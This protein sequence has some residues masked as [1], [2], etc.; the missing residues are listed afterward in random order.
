M[1]KMA[2]LQTIRQMQQTQEERQR[3]KD[4]ETTCLIKKLQKCCNQVRKEEE[5]LQKRHNK[6]FEEYRKKKEENDSLFDI[7][8]DMAFEISRLT[9]ESRKREKLLRKE[10]MEKRISNLNIDLVLELVKE[11]NVFTFKRKN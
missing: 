7:M 8:N 11:H 2:S 5:D 10:K 9:E 4:H 6:L 1:N 3:Q